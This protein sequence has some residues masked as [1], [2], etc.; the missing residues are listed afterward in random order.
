MSTLT[1]HYRDAT[2]Q[3]HD[4]K[5]GTQPVFIGRDPNSDIV[6]DDERVTRA[7]CEIRHWGGAYVVKDLKSKNGTFLND[8]PIDVAIIG[9]LDIIKV[10]PYL[11]TVFDENSVRLGETQ[12]V[13]VLKEMNDGKGFNTIMHQIVDKLEDE[14]T[15]EA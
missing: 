3:E 9:P 11:L 15:P 4:L 10:G 8:E 5:L 6:L 12:A 13:E 2:K 1:I 14:D 7:H